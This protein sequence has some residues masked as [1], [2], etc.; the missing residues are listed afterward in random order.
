MSQFDWPIGKTVKTM[1]AHKNRKLY[2]KLKCLSLRPKYTGEKG[3]TLGKTY[4]I[5][6][7]CYWEHPWGAHW[8]PLEHIGNSLGNLKG[9]KKKEKKSL[10]LSPH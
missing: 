7:R 8:E 5:N 1:E 3:R 10:S 9:T 4:G 6:A 2:G